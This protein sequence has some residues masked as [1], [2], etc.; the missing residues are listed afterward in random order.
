MKKLVLTIIAVTTLA[1]CQPG[2]SVPPPTWSHNQPDGEIAYSADV[3]P[4]ES[5]LWHDIK[6]TAL[7]TCRQ[8]G[9]SGM[10][11]VVPDYE[12][13]RSN[14]GAACYGYRLTRTFQCTG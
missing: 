2:G 12:C 5:F 1:G 8:W 3:A 4:G 10:E 6:A 13:K 7:S 14:P 9:Y 11:A